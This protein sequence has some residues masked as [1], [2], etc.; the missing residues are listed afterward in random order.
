MIFGVIGF[1]IWYAVAYGVAFAQLRD[2]MLLL[3]IAHAA[4]LLVAFGYL[5][6]VAQA[7]AGFSPFIFAMLLIGAMLLILFWQ[8]SPGNRP[9]FLRSYPRGTID[10]LLFRRPKV[11]DLKRRV[12][13]K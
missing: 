12:R 4:L 2:R 7:Q 10:V 11:T 3:Q 1:E 9:R 13:T 5:L 8:R 6:G